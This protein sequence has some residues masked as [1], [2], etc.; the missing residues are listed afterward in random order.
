M[1]K[2]Q[3]RALLA[4][5][6]MLVSVGVISVFAQPLEAPGK[7]GQVNAAAASLDTGV[8]LTADLVDASAQAKK[9][10]AVVEVKTTG[11]RLV[12]PRTTGGTPKAGEAHLHYRVDKGPVIATTA[13]SLGFHEL[14]P[15]THTI[16]VTLAANDHS[17]RGK[18]VALTV[19]I[20]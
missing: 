5:M 1:N 17:P 15:G 14:T 16:T 19:D 9:K 4:G 7:S 10:T 11:V 6:W 18:P 3:A 13:T 8:N 20:P 12:D 2:H